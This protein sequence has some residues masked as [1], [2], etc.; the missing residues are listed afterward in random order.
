MA[1]AHEV[2]E[3]AT[4]TT[5]L[6]VEEVQSRQMAG[7]DSATQER[8]E[9]PPS[10]DLQTG[11]T[12]T[13]LEIHISHPDHSSNSVSCKAPISKIHSKLRLLLIQRSS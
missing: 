3:S 9:A 5:Q 4:A 7:P 12:S 10:A 6:W 1:E 8:L 11:D 2:P 13:R